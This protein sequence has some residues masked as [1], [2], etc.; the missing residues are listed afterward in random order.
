[1]QAGIALHDRRQ[2]AGISRFRHGVQL[3][4]QRRHEAVVDRGPVLAGRARL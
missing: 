2:V 4:L 3:F 1:M